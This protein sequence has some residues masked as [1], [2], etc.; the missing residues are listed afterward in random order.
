MAAEATHRQVLLLRRK[1]LGDKDTST[2]TSMNEVGLA[3]DGQGKYKEAETIHRQTLALKEKVLGKENLEMLI[4][5]DNLAGVLNNQGKYEEAETMHRQTLVLIEKVIGK[6]HPSTLLNVY[7]LA[8]LLAKQDSFVE[9]TTL[10]QRA[11]EGYSVVFR[12]DHL[13]ARACRRH[14]LETLQRK[15][16]SEL[17]STSEASRTVPSNKKSVSKDG[18]GGSQMHRTSRLSRGL[19][20]LRMR[21]N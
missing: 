17:I 18:S 14:Y 6:E 20:K 9:A 19:A 8:H 16:Q 3:L 1:A 4:T 2:L 15:E 10:Y 12:D 13:T 5:M 21:S 7:C 11:C